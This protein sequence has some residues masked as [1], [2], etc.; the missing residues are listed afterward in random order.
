MIIKFINTYLNCALPPESAKH[1]IETNLE[2]HV[3]ESSDF[4][5]EHF[6][7]ILQ[8]TGNFEAVE[9]EYDFAFEFTQDEVDTFVDS[10]L[11]ELYDVDYND[12]DEEDDDYYDGDFSD[13][14]DD[15]DDDFNI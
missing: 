11:E 8:D 6:L 1:Y 9:G 2:D 4:D 10:L 7:E 15:E 12:D 5:L 13:D 14:E 3:R